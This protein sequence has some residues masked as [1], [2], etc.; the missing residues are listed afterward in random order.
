MQ[1]F[2]PLPADDTVL[3]ITHM[4]NEFAHPE[5]PSPHR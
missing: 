3:V 4:Q 1:G 5:P 2:P